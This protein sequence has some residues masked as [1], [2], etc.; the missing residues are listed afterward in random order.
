MLAVTGS[1]GKS[2]VVSLLA[3]LAEVIGV[4]AALAGNIGEPILDLL[5]V[6]LQMIF[7][8]LLNLK[9]SLLSFLV[10]N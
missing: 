3:Y 5:Q 8:V 6:R 2:T 1:N 7:N 4:N 10:S 9:L